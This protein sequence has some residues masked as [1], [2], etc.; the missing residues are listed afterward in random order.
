VIA[1]S[2]IL[3]SLRYN[4]RWL[5]TFFRGKEGMIESPYLNEIIEE[6]VNLRVGKAVAKARVSQLRQDIPRILRDRFG[7]LPAEFGAELDKVTD[8]AELHALADWAERCSDLDAFRQR[9]PK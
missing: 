4:D 8:I 2:Q 1:V 5:F 7:A 9:L 6:Q 3:A